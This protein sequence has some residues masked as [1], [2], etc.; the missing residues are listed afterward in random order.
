MQD[1]ERIL[2][3]LL[4]TEYPFIYLYQ[5]KLHQE[6]MSDLNCL[7]C[8]HQKCVTPAHV[9]PLSC[10]EM[11]LNKRNGNYDRGNFSESSFPGQLDFPVE[12]LF[13]C[14]LWT[15]KWCWNTPAAL[16]HIH[17]YSPPHTHQHG[18]VN[19]LIVLNESFQNTE[20]CTASALCVFVHSNQS[21]VLID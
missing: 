11:L 1:S 21:W 8:S 17:M 5:C 7:S 19:F 6:T 16:T 13:Y 2:K 20:K 18:F 14:S 12:N 3:T 9:N 15:F 4:W 10:S